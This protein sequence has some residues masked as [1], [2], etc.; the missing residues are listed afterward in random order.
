MH[1]ISQDKLL[2]L[3][4]DNVSS[5]EIYMP[6]DQF[7]IP[8]FKAEELM[9]KG[10]YL[11]VADRSDVLGVYDTCKQASDVCC[12]LLRAIESGMT[13]FNIE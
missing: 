8:N 11:L 7:F 3:N 13:S 10:K 5:Y 1:I 9:K 12:D 6:D 4:S 2:V